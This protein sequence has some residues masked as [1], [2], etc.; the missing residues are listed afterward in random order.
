MNGWA[1]DLGL[2]VEKRLSLAGNWY[3]VGTVPG[4]ASLQ[5]ANAIRER[6]RRVGHA[7]LEGGREKVAPRRALSTTPGR[8]SGGASRAMPRR[9]VL[10]PDGIFGRAAE[11][12]QP[13]AACGPPHWL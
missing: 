11:P 2:T 13:S 12:N 1:A 3:L 4:E 7:K 6:Q 8:R 5:T 10:G 9:P